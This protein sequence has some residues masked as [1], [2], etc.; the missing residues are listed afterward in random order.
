MIAALAVAALA[1]V[2]AH[3]GTSAARAPVSL[4]A[5]PARVTL[6]GNARE[7]VTVTNSGSRTVVVDLTRAGYALD[8]RGRPR[9]LPRGARP[10]DTASWLTVRPA[11]LALRPGASAAFAVSARLP[12]RAE[13]GDHGA[14]V[15][16]TTRPIRSAAVVVRMR[17]GV[18]VVVRAPGA[19]V[20]R[21]ALVRLRARP[22]GRPRALALWLANRGNVT[23]LFGSACLTVSLR[24]GSSVVARLRPAA[25]RLLP[26]TRGIIELRVP[27]RLR[28]WVTVRTEPSGRPPC[29]SGLRRA[30]R[31]RLY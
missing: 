24:R 12:R 26:R 16:L 21:L 8:L 30:I 3:A 31:V 17:V 23:E 28:G 6:A 5:A 4:V 22:A 29:G 25:R 9:I 11:R 14:L 10:G 7:T 1:L 13:P 27:R 19:I 18:V 2:P 20:R 15:L